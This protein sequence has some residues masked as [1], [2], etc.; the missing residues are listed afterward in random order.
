MDARARTGRKWLGQGVPAAHGECWPGDGDRPA[1]TASWG[2]CVMAPN[3]R[4]GWIGTLEVALALL[5]YSA[6]PRRHSCLCGRANQPTIVSYVSIHPR[7]RESERTRVL[8]LPIVACQGPRA[9]SSSCSG[10]GLVISNLMTHIWNIKY[11][12]KQKLITQ[13][14]YKSRDESFD[15]S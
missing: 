11:R 5:A 4:G 14:S 8:P 7:G 12:R 3:R 13:F 6:W 9:S 10:S 15:S 1:T 2:P